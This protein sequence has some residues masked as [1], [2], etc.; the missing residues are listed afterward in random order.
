MTLLVLSGAF[1]AFMALI[2][3][4]RTVD[5]WALDRFGYAPFAL[6]NV[7]FM[8]L[9]SAVFWAGLANLLGVDA[10]S[11]NGLANA[12]GPSLL[13]GLAAMV[14]LAF[15]WLIRRRTVTWVAAIAAPLLLVAAPVLLFSVLF[16]TLAISGQGGDTSG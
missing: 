3:A 10:G 14:A 6:I 7:L 11:L 5:R 4:V 8:L 9:P 15:A 2:G 12:L 13:L 1:L 16:G